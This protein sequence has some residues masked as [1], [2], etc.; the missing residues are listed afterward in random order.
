MVEPALTSTFLKHC[1]VCWLEYRGV[2]VIYVGGGGE[3]W[4]VGL[5]V[6]DVDKGLGFAGM[7]GIVRRLDT[8]LRSTHG[9]C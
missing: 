3:R 4:Y 8:Q 6:Q 7:V 5:D 2:L 1:F 9:T